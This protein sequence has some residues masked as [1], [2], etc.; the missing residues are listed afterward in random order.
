MFMLHYISN[1]INILFKYGHGPL[2]WISIIL[3]FAEKHSFFCWACL[4]QQNTIDRN[5]LNLTI[6]V[7]FIPLFDTF[8]YLITGS[9]G[10]W[11]YTFVIKIHMD[12]IFCIWVV[13]GILNVC[14]EICTEKCLR[15]LWY[16]NNG[17]HRKSTKKFHS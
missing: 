12:V 7:N 3:V 9:T 15:I 8:R 4:F 2:E 1:F 10:F 11:K 13:F 17:I 5:I 6:S 14:I 16:E